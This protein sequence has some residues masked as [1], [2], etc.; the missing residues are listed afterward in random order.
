[1]IAKPDVARRGRHQRPLNK[2]LVDD[3]VAANRTLARLN[4]LDASAMSA[5]AI[6]AIR[7]VT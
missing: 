5:C 6:R 3:L 1:M 7:T 4:V 2:E